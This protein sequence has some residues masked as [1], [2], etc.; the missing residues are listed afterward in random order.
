LPE[1]QVEIQSNNTILWSRAKPSD[2]VMIRINSTEA[3]LP[4]FPKVTIA[5]VPVTVFAINDRSWYAIRVMEVTDAQGIVPFTVEY[6]DL[7]GNVGHLVDQTSNVLQ[8]INV[9]FG[10][11]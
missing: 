9:T 1:L 6:T 8:G 4:S 11:D 2:Q 10:M 3:L 5:T 7:A